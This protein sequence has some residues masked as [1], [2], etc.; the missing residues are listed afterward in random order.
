MKSAFASLAAILALAATAGAQDDNGFSIAT[1]GPTPVCQPLLINWS[2]GSP[3]YFLRYVFGDQPNGTPLLDFGQQ[4]GNSF[5]WIVNI[6]A[7]QNIGF[8]IRDN[9]GVVKQSAPFPLIAS[10]DQSCLNGGSTGGGSS[11]G[12]SSSTTAGGAPGTSAPGG[13]PGTSAPAGTS[14]APSTSNTANPGAGGSSSVTKPPASS[15]SSANSNQTSAPSSANKV[16]IG[17]AGAV[18]AALLAFLA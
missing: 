7:G 17:L 1:P 11:A 12:T 14:A 18:G 13:A 9:N 15:S 10:S 5:R 8:T 6:T 3:P 4:T 16:E 2:G